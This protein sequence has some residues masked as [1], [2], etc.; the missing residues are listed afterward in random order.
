MNYNKL[1][2]LMQVNK[3]WLAVQLYGPGPG[4]SPTYKRPYMKLLRNQ[5]A[6]EPISAAAG[7]WIAAYLGTEPAHIHAQDWAAIHRDRKDRREF[8]LE[9][10]KFI[11]FLDNKLTRVR[12]VY[13]D[14]SLR[15][16]TARV[17]PNTTLHDL[18]QHIET[19][20]LT[21]A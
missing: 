2:E 17:A 1:T 20:R 12:V 5:K 11:A 6:G 21:P 3:D 14:G 16:D 9:G 8:R 19:G 18:V 13:T 15:H 4:K 7:A 10:R